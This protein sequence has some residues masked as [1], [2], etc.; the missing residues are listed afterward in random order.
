MGKDYTSDE[1]AARTFKIS[2]LLIGAFI[3][4]VFVFVLR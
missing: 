2:M 3:L 4:V 1:L